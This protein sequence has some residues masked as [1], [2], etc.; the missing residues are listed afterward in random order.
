VQKNV[1]PLRLQLAGLKL[2]DAGNKSSTTDPTAG[3]GGGG[4]GAGR[5]VG[6]GEGVG[7]G[8]GEGVGVGVGASVGVGLGCTAVAEPPQEAKRQLARMT[9]KSDKMVHFR[10]L[11][12]MESLRNFIRCI[13]ILSDKNSHR[14]FS[15]INFRK[16]LFVQ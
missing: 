5:G 4:G 3:G 16:T 15:G 1:L 10:Y 9:N 6:V 7:L 8:V 13:S 12:E 14:F 2:I 11:E